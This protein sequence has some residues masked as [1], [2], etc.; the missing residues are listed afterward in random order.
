MNLV[1][2]N[3]F[4]SGPMTGHEHYNVEQFVRAHAIAHELGAAHVYDPALVWLTTTLEDSS[5]KTHEDW[6]RKCVNE[7]TRPL[8]GSDRPRYDMLVTLDGWR[9]S[10]G[11][12]LEVDVAERC[13]IHIVT[14]QELETMAHECR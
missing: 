3:V 5:R 10:A 14:I 9:T 4:I 7:L 2:K 6:M 13:G 8:V 12:C 1:G 11:A